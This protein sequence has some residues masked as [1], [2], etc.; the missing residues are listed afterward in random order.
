MIIKKGD[1]QTDFGTDRQPLADILP[2]KRAGQLIGLHVRSVADKRCGKVQQLIFDRQTSKIRYLTLELNTDMKSGQATELLLPM[3][4]VKL[5]ES[6]DANYFQ[7]AFSLKQLKQAPR[8]DLKQKTRSRPVDW[9]QK[10]DA[11]FQ[12]FSSAARPATPDK[13][14]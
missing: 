7:G 10:V 9:T 5:V 13:H 6:D 14:E 8:I 12:Q 1:F 2:L 11:Y 3:T 4:A